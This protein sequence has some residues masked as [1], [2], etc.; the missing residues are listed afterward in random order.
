MKSFCAFVFAGA[1]ALAAP[2][3]I[4]TPTAASQTQVQRA[5]TSDATDFSAQRHVRRY[6]R[7]HGY[8]RP[9]YQPHYYDRP[10]YYR[11]YPYVS[12]APFTFGIGFGP[13]W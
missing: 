6:H 3:T 5:G 7:Q 4:N 2:A 10:V 9:Y 13:K 11:P 1:L 12:P 8:S